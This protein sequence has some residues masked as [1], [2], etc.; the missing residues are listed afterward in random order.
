V[1]SVCFIDYIQIEI[2]GCFKESKKSLVKAEAARESRG[3]NG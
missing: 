2:A 1:L 3:W